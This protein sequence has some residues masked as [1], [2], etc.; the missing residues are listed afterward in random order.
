MKREVDGKM[1]GMGG[2][3]PKYSYIVGM[4]V[5]DAW[6]DVWMGEMSE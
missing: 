2:E 1:G 3:I 6:K 5:W 4:G